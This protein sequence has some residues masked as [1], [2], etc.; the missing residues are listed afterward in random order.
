MIKSSY[1]DILEIFGVPKSTLCRSL[2]VIFRPLK[3]SSLKHLWNVIVVGKTTKIMVR[4]LMAKI[5]V[6]KK[7]KKKLTFS[8]TKKHT[9]WQHHK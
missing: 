7:L 1:S 9:L 5:V 4:K 8:R 6:K 3:C 2:G